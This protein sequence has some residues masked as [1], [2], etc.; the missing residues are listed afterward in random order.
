VDTVAETILAVDELSVSFTDQDR[1]AE[2]ARRTVVDRVGFTL[3]RGRVLA[4]VGESGSGKSVS[5]M[6]VL[7]LLPPDARVT[8][9][10]RLGDEDLLRAE[11]ARL[12]EIRGGVIGTVFQEPM[13][14]FN[15][16]YTI[17]R[18]IGE[19]ISAHRPHI[20]RDELRERITALLDSVGIRD[21]RRVARSYPHELSGGQLQRAMIAMAISGDPI[22]LIADE[23]T[24]ALDVTVQAGILDLIRELRDRLGTA[25]LLITHDM[26]VVADLADDVVVLRDGDVVERADVRTLFARPQAEYTKNLLDAVPR[27]DALAIPD[28]GV[29][30][31]RE[32]APAQEP[33]TDATPPAEIPAAEGPSADTPAVRLTGASVTF[34]IRGVGARTVQ[35]VDDVSFDIRRG[36]IFGLVGESGSGKSTIGRALVGLVP[37]S[38]GRVTVDGVDL[39]TVSGRA[40]RAARSRIGYVFQD[41]ASSLNPRFTIGQSIAEPLRLGSSLDR[42]GQ[43]ARVAELLEAVQL[44]AGMA[45]R[46]Q[47]ELSGGQRQRVAIARALA[48]RPALLIADE[49]T[50]ALDVSVQA[51]VLSLLRELQ[52]SL[53]FACLF[54]SHDLAVVQELVDDVAVLHD[55]RIVEIG[56]ASEVLHSPSDRYTQRLLAAAPVAD[57][58]AQRARRDAWRSLA[59]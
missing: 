56:P 52:S 43:R 20:G 24:T 36:E 1:R 5:A 12:R 40:R 34:R 17:G 38:A 27:L 25:V 54:I 42:A 55:G 16:V 58:V 29:A 7:G 3:E 10:I 33:V 37:L 53:G 2:G 30:A 35:A 50:S 22:A 21:T 4:L 19:A 49:P 32:A 14:A 15:P 45:E 44:G 47:H 41:P 51:T 13:S 57:P 8:G 48:L 18:Q 9:S 11:A 6:S 59:A 28:A 39:S 23:P 31:D 26:G 46:F